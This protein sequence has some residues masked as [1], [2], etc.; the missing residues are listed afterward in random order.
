MSQ[1]LRSSLILILVSCSS[2][3]GA[4]ERSVLH[5]LNLARTEPRAYASIVAE[6]APVLGISSRAVAETVRF[7]RKQKPVG[8]LTESAG[9]DQAALTHVFDTGPRG[10]KGHRGSDGSR[11]TQ[12]ADRFGRWDQLIGE[13]LIYGRGTPRDWIVA[14]I[15][16]EG[17]GDRY[18]RINIFKREFR[19][20]GI[21]SGAHATKGQMMV[22]DFAAKYREGSSSVAI[23]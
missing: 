7:L 13:N 18:H 23:R 8:A 15:V 17:I 5:E 21:A 12:R 1:F 6:R 16:D 20:V 9:L 3:A 19:F 22:T 2:F 14:L 4:I 10:I 11:V